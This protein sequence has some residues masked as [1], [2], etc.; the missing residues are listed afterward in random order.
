M[1]HVFSKADE[2]LIRAISDPEV[3]ADRTEKIVP[4]LEAAERD[5]AWQQE[6]AQLGRIDPKARIRR[7]AANVP[8]PVLGL[9]QQIDEN[10]MRDKRRFYR[11]LDEHPEW[12]VRTKAEGRVTI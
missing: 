1:R 11:W 3:L 9:M 4:Y 12:D 8:A 5:R 2:N 7:I 6:M 10:F